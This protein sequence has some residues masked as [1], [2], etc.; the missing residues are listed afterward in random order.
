MAALQLYVQGTRADPPRLRHAAL[1]AFA[2]GCLAKPTAVVV[3][4]LMLTLDYWPLGRLDRKAVTEKIPF[5]AL[6]T[7]FAAITLGSHQRTGGIDAPAGGIIE[8]V[9][10][11]FHLIAFYLGKVVWPVE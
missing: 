11:A 8:S 9:L 4:A 3:P 6:T 5:F 2:L 10:T 1:V 7:I